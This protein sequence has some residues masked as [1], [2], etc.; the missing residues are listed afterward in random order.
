METY[1]D[2]GFECRRWSPPAA[3]EWIMSG[4]VLLV[5][6][7]E[8]LAR[9]AKFQPG[10]MAVSCCVSLRQLERIFAQKFHRT[11]YSWARELRCRRAKELISEGWSIKAV[12]DELGFANESHLCHEFK[13]LYGVTPHTF[14]PL[15]GRL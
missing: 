7:W 12:V 11:P 9:D 10:S 14:A 4:R 8:K 15:G 13:K 1:D 6:D 2:D 3:V 5:K